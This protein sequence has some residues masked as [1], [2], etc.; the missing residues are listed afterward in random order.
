MTFD[1]KQR[2]K[3][4]RTELKKLKLSSLFVTNETNVRYLSGFRGGDSFL[5]IT[6]DSQFFLTDSRY[7]EEA[8]GSV[9]GFTIVEVTESTYSSIAE[10]VKKNRIKNIGFESMNL[11]YEIAGRL[12]GYLGPAKC[13]PT[14]NIIENLRAI[15][16]P[17]EVDAIKRSVKVTKDVL[18]DIPPEFS[19]VIMKEEANE[20]KSFSVK[21]KGDLRSP[22]VQI[23]GKLFR[24]NIG[25]MVVNN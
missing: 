24:L 12:A 14:K 15:K 25:T 1:H 18:K 13:V 7:T 5:V 8:Q 20:W 16:D 21:L 23:S 4:L 6:P 19:S 17:L 2:L 11:P 22:S 3:N 10:I 9:T